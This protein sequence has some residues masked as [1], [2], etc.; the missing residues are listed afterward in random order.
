MAVGRSAGVRLP[1]RVAAAVAPILLAAGCTPGTEEP[2]GP[3]LRTGGDYLVDHWPLRGSLAGDAGLRDEVT[4]VVAGWRTPDGGGTHDLASALWLGEV[5]GA[6]LGVVDFRPAGNPNETW[7]LELTGE[8]G[9]LAVTGARS[10]DG[11]VLDEHLLPVSSGGTPI[12][13]PAW[14]R[15]STRCWATGGWAVRPPRHWPAWTPARR[16]LPTAG[17]ARSASRIAGRP[18]SARFRRSGAWVWATGMTRR[19]TC[20]GR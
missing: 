4:A 5:D 11:T 15:P 9:G 7:L 19:S 18:G 16:W 17:W 20:P 1:G 3:V 12:S 14:P 13:A 10:Y 6:V 8:P 2:S